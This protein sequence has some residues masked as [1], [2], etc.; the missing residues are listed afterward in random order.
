[1]SLAINQV[2]LLIIAIFVL[3]VVVAL[4]MY[5]GIGPFKRQVEICDALRLNFC[6]EKFKNRQQCEQYFNC[7]VPED[8]ECEKW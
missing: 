6:C 7:K 2:V 4:F 8:Y 1:M 3:V 5:Y